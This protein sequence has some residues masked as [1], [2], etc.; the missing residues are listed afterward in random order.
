MSKQYSKTP[1]KKCSRLTEVYP[2]FL[3]SEIQFSMNQFVIDLIPSYQF[4]I[5]TNQPSPI[6]S[7]IIV[8]SSFLDSYKNVEI[9]YTE[10][11]KVEK[12][13][14]P[15]I[16][17][18]IPKSDATKKTRQKNIQEFIDKSENLE[19]AVKGVSEALNRKFKAR[20][21]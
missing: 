1:S 9:L 10:A 18:S 14:N 17:I 5:E 21:S 3:T 6:E 20:N 7:L 13:L 8:V 15:S 11:E 12:K 19:D 4:N 16:K 2:P